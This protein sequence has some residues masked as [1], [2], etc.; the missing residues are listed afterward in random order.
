[1]SRVH[2]FIYGHLNRF[3][4]CM[5]FEGNKKCGRFVWHRMRKKMFVFRVNA[6]FMDNGIFEKICMFR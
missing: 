2:T 4:G 6:Y 3:I 1:M 5:Q